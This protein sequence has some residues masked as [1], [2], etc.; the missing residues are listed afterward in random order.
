MVVP[1]ELALYM[2]M[3][4]VSLKFLKFL[5]PATGTAAQLGLEHSSSM[6]ETN[7]QNFGFNNHIN[8][9]KKTKNAPWPM[10]A[11]IGL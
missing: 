9:I 6:T 11:V 10:M 3:G 8:L 2:V 1:K 7:D 5:V 4:L